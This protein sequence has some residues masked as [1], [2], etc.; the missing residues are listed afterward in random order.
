LLF[1]SCA[2]SYSQESYAVTAKSGLTIRDE[3]NPSGQK[4]GKLEYG[5]V[6]NVIEKT[7]FT[8]TIID[9]GRQVRG[10]WVRVTF[11]NISKSVSAASSGFVFNGFL[12]KVTSDTTSKTTF[13]QKELELYKL[14]SSE[15][16]PNGKVGFVS[17]TD[18]YAFT[19]D[20]KSLVIAR[21]HLG[22]KEFIDD[23]YHVLSARHR[24]RFLAGLRIRETDSIFIYHFLSD[25]IYAAQISTMALVA[26][27]N[28]YGAQTPVKQ[29]DYMIGFEIGESILSLDAVRN[30]YSTTL[31]NIGMENPFN[32]GQLRP[33]LWEK[34]AASRFPISNETLKD[35]MK[36][37]ED[38]PTETFEFL[39]GNLHYYLQNHRKN[40]KLYA[41][42]FKVYR[43]SSGTLLL[44]KTFDPGEGAALLSLNTIRNKKQNKSIALWTGKLFKNRPPIIT[45]F[46]SHSFGCPAIY[47]LAQ[48]E[49]P[50]YIRC[51]NRH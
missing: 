20:D 32:N 8:L 17:L 31:V 46:I 50:I 18:G 11:E 27:I 13:I 44:D 10:N 7:D 34:I 33:V 15:N 9:E 3:P 28:K 14:S 24:S 22:E 6:V 49:T 43:A 21:E 23:N 4:I 39:T 45:D 48:T 51:D 25:A 26:K 38:L 5:M 1:V 41:R 12:E 36:I 19:D 16:T 42:H 2:F 40:G 47:F 30:Y 29:R 35:S 37:K